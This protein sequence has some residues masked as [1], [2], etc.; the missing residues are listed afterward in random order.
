M[1]IDDIEIHVGMPD[2]EYEA[3]RQ[4]QAKCEATT[5]FS[6]APTIDEMNGRLRSMAAKVGANA[7]I[8]VEYNSGASLTSWKSMKGTGLAVRKLTDDITCPLCAELIKRAAVKCKHCGADLTSQVA[9]A[10]SEKS[11]DLTSAPAHA[12]N[13]PLPEPLR[14]TNNPQTWVIVGGVIFV[15]LMILGTR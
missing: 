4:L 6:Q 10:R 7:V 9:L 14:E 8:N 1:K 11:Q 15:L 13:T 5:A 12:T 2:F 3:I